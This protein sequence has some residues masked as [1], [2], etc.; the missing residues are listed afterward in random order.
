MFPAISICIP[1]YKQPENL[2]RLLESIE[3]QTFRDFE[4]I[5][6]DDSPN[7]CL[8][9][10]IA[11]NWSF[12]ISHFRNEKSLG[13]PRNWNSAIGRSS[14][15]WIKLMHH[16]DWF[17]YSYSL[18]RFIDATIAHQN[19]KFFF[20]KTWIFNTCT[21]EKFLY[22]PVLFRYE[23]VENCPA[24]LFH[25]NVIGAPTTTFI[26]RDIKELYDENLIWLV[27]I[28]YYYR[29]ICKYGIVKIEE[30]L[31]STAEEQVHQLT[32]KL[33]DNKEVELKEFFY[34]YEKLTPIFNRTN[35]LIFRERILFLL[36]HYNVQRISEIRN[37]GFNGNI[38][39]FVKLFYF[40][41][42]LNKKLAIQ[43]VGKWLQI[44]LK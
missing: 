40:L 23:A 12:T 28:E 1:A 19:K 20:C 17:E 8:N 26:H 33:K 27:D 37:S 9:N 4:V 15:S 25:A 5:I 13:S 34:C 29:L 39:L 3:I 31:I 30:P 16:D 11:A 24:N 38:P 14:G 41:R 42:K 22:Q 43:I 7:D 6:T 36:Q 35:H 18:Q 44:L 2:K 21:N 32:T 10:V